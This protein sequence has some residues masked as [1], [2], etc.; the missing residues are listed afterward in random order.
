MNIQLR[1]ILLSLMFLVGC[2]TTTEQKAVVS[3]SIVDTVLVSM[4]AAE[5]P[6]IAL[7]Q[8]P[9]AITELN[10]SLK[11]FKIIAPPNLE[12]RAAIQVC[13][14]TD[15]KPVLDIALDESVDKSRCFH[16]GSG[17]IIA[18]TNPPNF[19]VPLMIT[20]GSAHNYYFSKRRVN[21]PTKTTVN[22]NSV[23]STRSGN[24]SDTYLV[25]FIDKNQDHAIN[26]DELWF[27]KVKWDCCNAASK[28][29]EYLV[30]AKFSRPSSMGES[31]MLD[32]IVAGSQDEAVAK[33]KKNLLDVHSDYEIQILQVGPSGR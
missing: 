21:E 18:K 31:F 29:T 6:M 13:A 30:S 9:Q 15:N 33:Y 23:T 24:V 14:T 28:G 5:S 26:K 17:L 1:L 25:V 8:D 22:I 3:N 2:S 4:N 10:L 11:G 27:A 16:D 12:G 19:D 32:Y 20:D 7:S